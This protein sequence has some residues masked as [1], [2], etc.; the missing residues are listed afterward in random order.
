MVLMAST[1]NRKNSC[2]RPS[3]LSVPAVSYGDGAQNSVAA[4]LQVTRIGGGASLLSN[5]L[6]FMLLAQHR[7]PVQLSALNSTTSLVKCYVK[8]DHQTGGSEALVQPDDVL[9]VD[10]EAVENRLRSNL[11][12]SAPVLPYFD[13][14]LAETPST[15]A[16][17][18]GCHRPRGRG[19]GVGRRPARRW[20]FGY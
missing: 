19:H 18:C 16:Q 2:P 17:R 9:Q 6:S 11:G 13:P 8:V 3:T 14:C 4:R 5:R 1:P 15:A 7:R 12:D 10:G 20:R